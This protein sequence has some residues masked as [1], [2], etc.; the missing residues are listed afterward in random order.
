VDEQSVY[1]DAKKLEVSIGGIIA[2]I[3]TQGIGRAQQRILAQMQRLLTDARLDVRD[4]EY[5]DTKVEQLQMA[6]EARKRFEQLN[7]DLIACSEYNIFSAVDVALY[8]A[9]IQHII[10]RLV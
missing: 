7:H 6:G 3:D 8:S 1:E 4:Y 9:R 5:A 2:P 10:A